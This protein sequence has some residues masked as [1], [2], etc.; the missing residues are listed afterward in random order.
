MTEARVVK[1]RSLASR[2][3][4]LLASAGAKTSWRR[5]SMA[6]IRR[7]ESPGTGTWA[8]RR[9]G[10]S[11]ARRS[12]V[13]SRQVTGESG[14][15]G[16]LAEALEELPELDR[17]ELLKPA[18]HL[19]LRPLHENPAARAGG[20]VG[21]EMDLAARGE[22]TRNGFEKDTPGGFPASEVAQVPGPGMVGQ[23]EWRGGHRLNE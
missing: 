4:K 6:R 1:W 11:A 13:T 19:L 10:V 5:S 3:M 8:A 22:L 20:V 7:A 17:A 2:G 21:D 12:A 16:R 14:R 23:L 18:Q 9:P 15:A